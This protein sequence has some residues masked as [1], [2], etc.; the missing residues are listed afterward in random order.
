MY[1]SSNK[2]QKDA[3][4]IGVARKTYRASGAKFKVNNTLG[5]DFGYGPKPILSETET[6]KLRNPISSET[7]VYP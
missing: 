6:P 2:E 1:S 5:A 3:A 4:A 7:P